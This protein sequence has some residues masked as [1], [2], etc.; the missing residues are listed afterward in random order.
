MDKP[1]THKESSIEESILE[2]KNK[3]LFPEKILEI[4]L[5]FKKE[6]EEAN[7]KW[8]DSLKSFAEKMWVAREGYNNLPKTFEAMSYDKIMQKEKKGKTIIWIG[9]PW[10]SGKNTVKEMLS[11]T[12]MVINTTTRDQRQNEV[13]GV[14]YH[15][16]SEE[17][18]Q[19]QKDDGAFLSTTHRPWRGNYGIKKSE[20]LDM[21]KDTKALVIEENPETIFQISEKLKELDND[22]RTVLVY[23]LPPDPIIFHLAS[24]LANRSLTSWE[25]PQSLLDTVLWDRQHQEFLSVLNLMDKMDVF[26]VVNDVPQRAKDLIESIYIVPEEK[27]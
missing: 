18:F 1:S 13:D 15:F 24:R 8:S 21:V 5:P 26:F 4:L 22:C 3:E 9:W 14:H 17:D 7:K 16:M 11:E 10:A 25:S 2:E 27:A 23:I 12:K 6:I 20:I 19:K